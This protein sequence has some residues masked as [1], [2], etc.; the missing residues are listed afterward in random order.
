MSMKIRVFSFLFLALSGSCFLSAQT[1]LPDSQRCSPKLYIY[2]ASVENLRQIYLKDERANENMLQLFVTSYA[3]NEKIPSLP[4]GNYFVVGVDGNQMVFN[5]Y[6]VDDFYFKIIQGEKMNLCLYDSQGQ[7]IREAEVKCGSSKIKFDSSTQTYSISKVKDRQIVEVNNKGVLHYIEIEKE[8]SS[9][10]YSNMNLFQKSKRT[11]QRKW[12]Q[13]KYSIRLLFNPDERPI[14]RPIKNKYK[15]FIVFNKPKYKPGETVKLKAYMTENNGKPYNK[16]VDIRFYNDYYSTPMD[17]T[18]KSAL[19]PYRPGMYQYEFKLTDSL[20]LKLDSYYYIELKT[21]NEKE[22]ALDNSFRYEEYELKSTQFSIETKKTEYAAS[23]SVKIKFKATDENEMALYGGKAELQI[24][25]LKFGKQDMNKRPSVFIPNVLWSETIDM[26]DESEKEITIPDSIFPSGISLHF[27]VNC[28]YLSADNEIVSQSKK[29]FRNSADYLIDFSMKKGILAINELYEGEPQST[30]AEILISGENGETILESSVV[31]PYQLTVPWIASD[32]EVKT[33]NANGFFFLEYDVEED[34]IGYQFY[35]RNDS[36]FLKIENPANIPFWYVMRKKNKEI[37]KGYATQLNYSIKNDQQEGYGMQLSYF[38]GKKRQ[39]EEMLPFARKNMRLDVS[40]PTSV[41]PGQKTN[42]TVSVRDKEDKPIKNVDITAYAFTSKFENYSMPYL[43]IGGKAR[44]A[45]PFKN[46][47][48]NPDENGIH[49]QSPFQWERWK[50]ALSLDTLE[51]YK[52]LYPDI[53]Y[54]YEEPSADG[55]AQIAPYLVVN[56]VLQGVHLLWIDEQLHYAKQAQQLNTYLFRIPPGR[57]NLRFRT[58]NREVSV[59]NV[60]IKEGTKT[61]LSFDAGISFI[62][63]KVQ[64]DSIPPIVLVSKIVK[65]EEQGRLSEKETDYLASQLITVDNNFGSI[66]FPKLHS[67]FEWPAYIRTGNTNYYLNPARRTYYDYTLHANINTPILAGPFPYRSIINDLTDMAT[68]YT[69]MKP[70]THFQIEGGYQY[71]LFENYQ[72]MKSWERSPIQNQAQAFVPETDFKAGLLSEEDISNYFNTNIK[73]NLISSSGR[74]D[75]FRNTVDADKNNTCRMTLFW[76]FDRNSPI[77]KPALI[78]IVPQ[79]K[80][81]IIDYSLYYGGTREFS[82]LPEGDMNIHFIFGDTTSYT[83]PIALYKDGQNYLQLDSV[84]RDEDNKPAITA[85]NLLQRNAIKSVANNPYANIPQDTVVEIAPAKLT[86]KFRKDNQLK[87]VITGIVKDDSGEAL[88]GVSISVKGTTIGTVTDFDGRF[89]LQGA[90]AGDKIAISYIGFS[91]VVVNYR[92]GYDY[93]IVMKEDVQYLK[94]V[95]VIGYGTQR[96]TNLTESV[97]SAVEKEIPDIQYLGGKLAGTMIRGSGA[98]GNAASTTEGMAPLIIVNGLPYNGK[99]EDLN[100]SSIIS[101]NVLKDE[102]AT[103]LYGSRAANGIIMIQTNT[104]GKQK[105]KQGEKDEIEATD[106]GNS[107]RRNFHDDAFWQPALKTDEKGK[108]SF[109]VT[110]PDD[111]TSWNAYFLAIGNRK[112]ADKKQL[113]IQ[114]FKALTAHLSTPRFAIRGDSLNAIGRIANHLNDSIEVNE[115]ATVEG[116]SQEKKIRMNAS[117]VES[118]PAIVSEGDSITL[119]YSISQ[120]TGYFDGEERS[121]PVFEQGL[122]QTYGEFKIISDTVTSTFQ[123]NSDLGDFTLHAETSSMDVFLREMEKIDRYP[124]LCNEQMASKIKALLSKKSATAI[125]GQ[126]FKDD[127]NIKELIGRLKN[128]C[129]PEGL[130]GWWDKSNTEFWISQHVISAL[131]DAEKAGYKTG[132]D[133]V[134]LRLVLEQQL[135]DGLSKLPMRVPFEDFF[136]KQELLDRLIL[137][138]KLQS[139]IDYPAYYTQIDQQLKSKMVNDPLKEMLLFSMLGMNEKINIDT[140]MHYARKTILGSMFWGDEKENKYSYTFLS[141]YHNNVESTLMAYA[142][143]KNLGGHETELE[144]IRDYFFERRF[145]GSWQ[146]TYEASRIIETILPDMLAPNTNYSEV[147]MS[148]DNQRVSTF[149]FTQKMDVK[150]PVRIKKEGTLPLFVTVYQQEWNRNPQPE[151][152]KGFTVQ[153]IFKE[154]QDTV[155]IL[156]SGKTAAL[157]VIVKVAADAEYV[158]I[159][160]PIPA[161]CSYESKSNSF[162]GTETHREYFKEKVSI[163]CNRLIQGEHRFTINLIPRFTGKYTLNPAKAELMYF[164]TFYGNEKIKSVEIY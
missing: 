98:I 89:E 3:R 161:G 51:Y 48:Y 113:T 150:Q 108:V 157:E 69:D 132:I 144:K 152:S 87:G 31:L 84:G 39:A 47:E 105:E 61:I 158:Q 28:K 81:N 10:Y 92:E 73:N 107:M 19:S 82:N 138:K 62:R 78:L 1:R 72:K 71:T 111:I 4:K 124:Y 11:V 43:T 131:L 53:L 90:S 55:T 101:V 115:T 42:I 97:S 76:G 37:A 6:T 7:I 52:F 66:E 41:Y 79:N 147:S 5:D 80:E 142:T 129:N 163:F 140:L 128:N 46:A 149:P 27:N 21:K 143:L 14:N 118:I 58:H 15:G 94:E 117:H 156:Q 120:P 148:I 29:L 16:P 45:R 86:G 25:P 100:P 141:P 26:N 159:E 151:S 127:K 8:N 83:I 114:S 32:I 91:P 68:L 135:K 17:T 121:F 77:L 137:L 126:E 134:K 119:A 38:F 95:V 50:Q 164:P 60:M 133:T 123:V 33:K 145:N 56:G 24:T 160:A 116:I 64:G 162:Y 20:N 63:K 65:K 30:S 12:H 93:T 35:R 88:I 23:D 2:K 146:N 85:F 59:N 74:I 36:I 102:A 54:S 18:L 70:V 122:L 9:D 34:P 154:N 22:N 112:Q 139:P 106:A 103:S 136:A 13:L 130:W 67:Y 110:Y 155:S 75:V 49:S 109:E 125:L 44:Y 99:W 40:T 104:L 96:K 153:T 57:H